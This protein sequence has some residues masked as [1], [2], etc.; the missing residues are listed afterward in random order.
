MG[1][2]KKKY[3]EVFGSFTEPFNS[4]FSCLQFSDANNFNTVSYTAVAA[5]DNYLRRKEKLH[6]FD[7]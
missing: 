2:K 3:I 6:S 1:G 4:P 7:Q 5:H